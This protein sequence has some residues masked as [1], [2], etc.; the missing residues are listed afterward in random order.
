MTPDTP[1]AWFGCQ[2]AVLSPK[3]EQI[4]SDASRGLVDSSNTDVAEGRTP[5]LVECSSLE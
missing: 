5:S 2:V 1:V 4:H 3:T